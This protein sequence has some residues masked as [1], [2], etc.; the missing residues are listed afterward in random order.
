MNKSKVIWLSVIAGIVI[1]AIV[2]TSNVIG[3]GNDE[4]TLRAGYEQ[5]MDERTAFYDKMWKVLSDKSKIT[6]KMDTSFHKMINTIMSNRKDGEGV[7]M[8]WVTESNPGVTFDKVADMYQS[9]S[10]TL[11]AEREGFFDQEKVLQ[12]I[13]K[14]HKLLITNF[15]G[16]FYNMFYHKEL[17]VYKPIT[18]TRTDEVMKT[19]KDD[20]S[21]VF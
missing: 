18:S 20:K 5:K 2:F 1:L 17:L 16:K 7:F 15:P 8:K 4:N 12:D 3:F 9:L 19:G 13:V 21:M 11:E 14:Q 10:R 6:L